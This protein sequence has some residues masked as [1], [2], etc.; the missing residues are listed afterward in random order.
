MNIDKL[1]EFLPNG[2]N[3]KFKNQDEMKVF[4]VKMFLERTDNFLTIERFAEFYGFK[5]DEALGIIE[6][7]KRLADMQDVQG[8]F[9]NREYK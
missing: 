3:G 6:N 9:V 7:G 8:N 2:Y 5:V 1:K 4:C